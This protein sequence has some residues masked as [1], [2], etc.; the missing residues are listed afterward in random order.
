[1]TFDRRLTGLCFALVAFALGQGVLVANGNL[2]PVSITSLTVACIAAFLAVVV[3][4]PSHFEFPFERAVLVL[5]TGA[6]AYQLYQLVITPPG[7]YL[8]VRS[9]N[10]LAPFYVGLAL[11]GLSVGLSLSSRPLLGAATPVL[12]VSAFVF[13]GNWM[14]K[15][16]PSPHIDVFVFLKDASTELLSGKNPWAMTFPDIYGNSPFYGEGVSV[17]GRVMS[18]IPYFPLSLLLVLPGHLLGDVRYAL[19]AASALAA[20]LLMYARPSPMARLMAAV[21]LFHP[22]SF[23]VVEQAWTDPQVVFGLAAVVFVATRF[24]KALP[25][26]FG[27]FLASKQYL[28]FAVP[29]GLLLFEQKP[30]RQELVRFFGIAFG[31]GALVTVP[32]FLWNPGAFWFSVV[33][34]QTIQPF[35]TESMSFLAW[36][37]QQGHDKPST[38]WAFLLA[39]L[40]VGLGVWRLPKGPASFAATVAASLLVFFAFNKQAFCN[41]YAFVIGAAAIAAGANRSNSADEVDA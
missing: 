32:F 33:K 40:V 16:S 12:M 14:I 22:R 18:G 1:M 11:A 10:D 38:A 4:L 41:Y 39:A 21:Y 24:P 27:L 29:A 20:L 36:W 13:L 15:T 26:V 37:V 25:Y 23:F 7:I 31:V 17:N 8:Q 6:F 28:I 19:V 35:R 5:L 9:L 34:L 30:T 2:H 3:R